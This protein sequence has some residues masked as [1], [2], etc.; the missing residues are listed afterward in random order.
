[1]RCEIGLGLYL[2]HT[3]GTV[4]GAIRVGNN[5]VIYHQVTIG[6]KEMDIG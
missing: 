2:P 3:I 6:A 5:A 1:M 4:I